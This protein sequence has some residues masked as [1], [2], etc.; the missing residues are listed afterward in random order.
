M[1]LTIVGIDARVALRLIIIHSSLSSL[2][3]VYLYHI[4]HRTSMNTDSTCAHNV[5]AISPCHQCLVCHCKHL[6]YCRCNQE[7]LIL[8]SYLLLVKLITEIKPVSFWQGIK[9]F[10]KTIRSVNYVNS[11]KTTN[12]FVTLVLKMFTNPVLC[13]TTSILRFLIGLWPLLTASS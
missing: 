3:N 8:L 1:A 12:H 11:A 9:Y 2:L 10:I 13:H 7:L 6:R 4:S 5:V